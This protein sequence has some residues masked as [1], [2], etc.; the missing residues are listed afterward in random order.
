MTDA[1]ET[2]SEPTDVVAAEPEPAAAAQSE[3]MPTVS[4]SKF[5]MQ[6][7]FGALPYLLSSLHS[8]S[9]CCWCA[10]RFGCAGRRTQV[11]GLWHAVSDAARCWV[12]G[13]VSRVPTERTPCYRGLDRGLDAHYAAWE[14]FNI[15][16]SFWASRFFWLTQFYQFL[17][18]FQLLLTAPV[19]L[20]QIPLW[21]VGTL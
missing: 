17:D 10:D 2:Q 14:T 7:Q 18:D 3:E 16:V 9:G 13:A 6:M 20:F 21:S 1:P 15:F 5:F 12:C 8:L 11:G 4:F 19:C